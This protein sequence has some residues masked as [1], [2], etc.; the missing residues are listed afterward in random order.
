MKWRLNCSLE[1]KLHY[2]EARKE[3]KKA[4]T[5]AKAAHFST[6]ILN[7]NN[8]SKEIFSIV[9]ELTNAERVLPKPIPTQELC[10][11]LNNYFVEKISNIKVSIP[12]SS[13]TKNPLALIGNPS[14][15]EHFPAIYIQ[16]FLDLLSR[17]KS[18]SPLDCC[19]PHILKDAFSA[20]LCAAMTF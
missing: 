4:I 19:P 6:R 17:V 2:L 15:L 13:P 16:S 3:Y 9:N 8:R 20:L 10:N 18:G 7:S 12:I 1:G 5:V 14:T 11:S